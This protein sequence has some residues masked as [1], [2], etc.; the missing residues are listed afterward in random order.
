MNLIQYWI[1]FFDLPINDGWWI[2]L[3]SF[4]SNS[5]RSI[6]VIS[7]FHSW[8]WRPNEHDNAY[9]YK[10]PKQLIE[11]IRSFIS[12]EACLRYIYIF[13]FLF[14]FLNIEHWERKRNDI[15]W[16]MCW[17]CA[18]LCPH[19]IVYKNLKCIHAW[20]HNFGLLVKRFMHD[21]VESISI[22]F[23]LLTRFPTSIP[24]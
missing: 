6:Y 5:I 18:V 10:M 7:F 9:T 17:L 22:R 16:S 2:F 24:F 1:S 8:E 23:F 14:S 4:I 12:F 3:S 11:F 15:E 20:F 19:F 13:L 21:F